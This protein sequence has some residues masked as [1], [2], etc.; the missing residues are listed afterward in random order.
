MATAEF[1]A[2]LDSV[3]ANLKRMGEEIFSGRANVDPYRQGAATA[4]DQCEYQSICRID[5][6]THRFRVL[7][8][9]E[10]EKGEG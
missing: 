9:D 1:G 6:W 5:P 7:R 8:K 2:L 3:E 4:C 10:E